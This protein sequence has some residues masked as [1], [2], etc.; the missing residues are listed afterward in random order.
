MAHKSLSLN[1]NGITRKLSKLAFNLS[2]FAEDFSI[3]PKDDPKQA[4]RIRRFFIS[5]FVYIINMPLSYLAY[6]GGIMQ[7]KGLLWGWIITIVFNIILYVVFRT[8]L[9]KRMKDPSLTYAQLCVAILV[10][11]YA[12]FFV[13]EAKRNSFCSL[14]SYTFVRHFPPGYQAVFERQRFYPGDLWD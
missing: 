12:M 8:G 14:R 2:A 1:I 11:M 10:V 9:N 6:T 5:L 13:Y 7:F 3:I 4:L